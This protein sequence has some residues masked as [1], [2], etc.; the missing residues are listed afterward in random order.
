M[1]GI[2]G[3]KVLLENACNSA[4]FPHVFGDLKWGEF[5]VVMES[6]GRFIFFPG[7]SK[8]LSLTSRKGKIG[9]EDREHARHKKKHWL[10]ALLKGTSCVGSLVYD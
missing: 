10:P 6:L 5:W 7:R 8:D 9:L 1:V 3:F 2:G 4:G